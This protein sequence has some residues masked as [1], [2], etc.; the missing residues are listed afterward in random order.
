VRLPFVSRGRYDDAMARVDAEHEVTQFLRRDLMSAAEQWSALVRK[1]EARADAAEARCQ[2]LR[3]MGAVPV[4]PP[5]AV[6]VESAIDRA[7]A[8]K[9]RGDPWLRESMRE[10]V[11]RD[12]LDGKNDG[13]I[14]MAIQLGHTAVDGGPIL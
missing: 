14:L 2:Q 10:Q 11:E 3:L 12:R 6:K 5:A 13:E 9:C 8:A 4:P 7:I 1:A